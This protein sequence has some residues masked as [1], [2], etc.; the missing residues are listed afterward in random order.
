MKYLLF[1]TFLFSLIAYGDVTVPSGTTETFSNHDFNRNGIYELDKLYLSDDSANTMLIQA[2]ALA[3][4]NTV[5]TFPPDNGS[6]DEVLKTNGSGTLTW[7][8]DNEGELQPGTGTDSLYTPNVSAADPT[9]INAIVIGKSATTG[10]NASAIAV[11]NLAT[12]T[13]A[14]S[15]SIGKNSASASTSSIA[16][17]GGASAADGAK[18]TNTNAIA[19]GYKSDATT[20]AV[21]LGYN[22]D[23]NFSSSTA[24]GA[25]AVTTAIDQIMLGASSDTVVMPGDYQ[26]TEN[27]TY[28][29]ATGTLD[30]DDIK[31]M[32]AA[33]VMLIGAPGGGKAIVVENMEILHS[34]DD[35][36]YADGGVWGIQYHTTIHFGGT[37]LSWFAATYLTDASDSHTYGIPETNI[38]NTGSIFANGL[39]FTDIENQGVYISNITGAFTGGAATNVIKWR[40]IYKEI[41]I[42]N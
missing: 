23:A 34:Y 14:T 41:T 8:L 9:A 20:R 10:N 28:K 31:A 4:D 26:H 19:I 40:I 13:G 6:A 2:P 1:I 3:D 5:F 35:T 36:V 38:S 12:V 39:D 17:G 32:Y 42:L 29:V 25:D 33:P 15:I 24:L 21:A 11:G 16:I 7:E 37:N 22:T 27:I 30:D 18:A